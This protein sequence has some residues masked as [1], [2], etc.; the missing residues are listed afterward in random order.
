MLLFLVFILLVSCS[1]REDEYSVT[2]TVELK[3]FSQKE[4]ALIKEC[5]PILIETVPNFES[6]FIHSINEV[7]DST[8]IVSLFPLKSLQSYELKVGDV[9]YGQMG[10]DDDTSVAIKKSMLKN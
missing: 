3:E 8:V 6:Y 5:Y 2:H 9:F 10:F 4:R 1:S 7:D